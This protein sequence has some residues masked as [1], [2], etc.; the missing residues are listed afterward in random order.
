MGT[1]VSLK[2]RFAGTFCFVYVY[3]YM[4]IRSFCLLF[5]CLG[6]NIELVVHKEDK[7]AI[8]QLVHDKLQ[9]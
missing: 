9:G 2:N 6:Y 1:S 5:G 3:M 4:H 7:E 8:Q